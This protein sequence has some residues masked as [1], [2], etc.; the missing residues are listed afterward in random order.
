MVEPAVNKAVLDLGLQLHRDW[1]LKI[2][3]VYEMCLVRHSLML[4]GPSGTGKSRIV[5]VLQKALQSIVVPPDAMVEPMIGQPQKFVTMNPKAI[6]SGQMFG[7]LDVV[8]NEWTDGVFAQLWRKANKDKKNFTWLVLDGPVD[9][10]WIENMNTVMDDNRLL[11]LANNDR[12]P[13]LRPNVTLH[14][15]VEDLRNAS[16]ATVSRAG[17]IYVSEADLGWK[18]FVTSWLAQ[19]TKD[20]AALTP[21]FEKFAGPL[22]DFVRLECK[23]KMAI[24][25]ISLMTSCSKLIDALLGDLSESP[26]AAALERF[27]IYAMLWSVAG[28]LE[29]ADRTK[30]DKLIRTLTSNLPEVEAPDTVF[31]YRINPEDFTWSS[32][33]SAIP[34]WEFSGEPHEL[35]QSFASLLIPTIDSVRCEYNLGL[36]VSQQRAVILVGG[37]GTAKTSIILQVLGKADPATETFKKMSFSQATTPSIFQRQ[38]E[39]SVEKRQGKTFGPAGGK[40]MYVFIDDISMPLINTWG[41]QI[42]LEIVRQMIENQGFYN[43]DKPGEFKYIVDLLVLGAMLHPGAGKNDIPN[44]AKRHFH[45]MNVT[46]PSV[47]SINQIFGAMGSSFFGHSPDAG[48]KQMSESLVSMTIAIWESVK[49]KM[50]PTPAKFHYLFNLRDLS[51]VFQGIFAIDVTKTLDSSYTLLA[52]WKHEC[53]RVFSDKLVDKKDKAWFAKEIFNVLDAFSSQY[54]ADIEKLKSVEQIYFV[55]FLRD[56]DEDPETGELL[57]AP[58]VYE[59]VASEEFDTARQKAKEYMG[60]LPRRPRAPGTHHAPVWSLPRLCAPRRRRWQR[61]AVAHAPR[62]VHLQRDVLP[63]HLDED[64]QFEQPSRG[65]QASLPSCGRAGEADGLHAHRQGDQG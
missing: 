55:D 2:I 1:I 5:E 10:I 61:Q 22:L 31:E 65:L 27:V 13:M 39:S 52:L 57:A 14:F 16:P 4:V 7:T 37:P 35:G 21:I 17:I 40:R 41:D 50:L 3:Q 43:L 36:S 62:L 54:G 6:L 29:A 38:I 45:V 28:V 33:G 9:A 25:N 60:L 51:R 44:R 59:P 49:K 53:M 11:T 26:D 30:V 56:A 23:A 58:K 20:G 19:R 15:E 46:L 47:A 32:W 64:V 34:S 63:D 42:T 12:I 24:A 18:P 8:A 48:V